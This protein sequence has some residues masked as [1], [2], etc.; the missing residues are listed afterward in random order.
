M[1]NTTDDKNIIKKIFELF[2]YTWLNAYYKIID[3]YNIKY[4]Y[5]VKTGTDKF[6]VS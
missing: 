6:I 5:F 4:T 1:E 2:I 3:V